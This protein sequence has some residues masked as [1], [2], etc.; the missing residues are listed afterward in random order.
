[1]QSQSVRISLGAMWKTT[2][3]E[4]RAGARRPGCSE[5]G[6]QPRGENP[7]SA[8]RRGAPR[9]GADRHTGSGTPGLRSRP[10]PVLVRCGAS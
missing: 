4:V 1:M 2:A 7:C 9:R 5:S 10:S 8:P 6:F 3:G